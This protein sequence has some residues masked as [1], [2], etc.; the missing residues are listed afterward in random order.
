[1]FDHF[2]NELAQTGPIEGMHEA[3]TIVSAI[4]AVT[5]RVEIGT[6]VL[7]LSFP[8]AGPRRRRWAATA[9]EVSG[10]RL[11]LGLGAGWH[12]PDTGRSAASP[13]T[14]GSTGSKRRS[15]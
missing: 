8:V 15:I 10:G 13:A 4:A 9:D 3:W 11:I 2:F 5:E 14:I 12:D 1:M 7:C 6:L